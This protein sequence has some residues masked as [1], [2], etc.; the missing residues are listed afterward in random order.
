MINVIVLK[1]NRTLQII[2]VLVF[3]SDCS[4]NVYYLN[5]LEMAQISFV[6]VNIGQ[7]ERGMFGSL[8]F[9]ATH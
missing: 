1:E 2:S 6:L 8:K 7:W 3:A 4:V 5:Q 9:W